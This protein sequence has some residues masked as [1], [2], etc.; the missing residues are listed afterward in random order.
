MV[1]YN[2]KEL[3]V[4]IAVVNADR[5]FGLL[6][7]DKLGHCRE[8]IDRCFK[9]EVSAKLPKMKGAK[10]SNKVNFDAK[11]DFFPGTESTIAT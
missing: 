4:N 1:F 8:S 5:Y 6:G 3:N 7:R 2:N 9:A 11:L 10:A